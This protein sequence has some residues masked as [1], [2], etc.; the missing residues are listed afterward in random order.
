MGLLRSDP[1]DSFRTVV[2]RLP[3]AV[4]D[5]AGA[6]RYVSPA[7]ATLLGIDQ[8]SLSDFGSVV[9]PADVDAVADAFLTVRDGDV[10]ETR[11]TFRGTGDERDSVFEATLVDCGGSTPVDC[12][13]STPADCGEDPVPADCDDTTDP[14]TDLGGVLVSLADVTR[15]ERLRRVVLSVVDP[16]DGVATARTPRAVVDRL[17]ELTEGLEAVEVGCY[18]RGDETAT[19]RPVRE[20]APE[21]VE[22]VVRDADRTGRVVAVDAA[23]FPLAGLPRGDYAAGV[24][25]PLG[26]HGVLVA[27]T[28]RETDVTAELVAF[29]RVAAATTALALDRL[30]DRRTLRGALRASRRYQTGRDRLADTVDVER[31]A[32][33]RILAASSTTEV[34]RAVCEELVSTDSVAFAWFGTVSPEGD[35]V[36]R[37]TA[38]EGGDYLS[39]VSFVPDGDDRPPV[40]RAVSDRTTVVE[41]DLSA[42]FESVGWRR[43]ALDA[44]FRSALA[45]PVGGDDATHGVLVCYGRAV[46][47]FDGPIR[48]VVDHLTRTVE[49]ALTTVELR[50]LALGNTT[51]ELVLSITAEDSLLSGLAAATGGTVQFESASAIEGGQTRV[52]VTVDGPTEAAVAAIR[53]VETVTEVKHL[54]DRDDGVVLEVVSDGRTIPGTLASLGAVVTDAETTGSGV[55]V[56]VTVSRDTPVREFV[57]S[58]RE[59][60]P[61]TTLLARR[62]AE[63]PVEANLRFRRRVEST[64]TERQLETLQTAHYGGY[65]DSPRSRTGSDIAAMLDITQ[66]TFASHLREA[67]RKLLTLLFET[68]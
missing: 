5:P 30:D 25:V 18:L 59:T 45:V 16:A 31:R 63:S 26:D 49:H 32:E 11:V 36:T 12:G 6:V 7:A 3:V 67:Q 68:T 15:S 55:R 33:R 51:I 8:P 35:L 62:T 66:P 10:T 34:Q 40:T 22:S 14:G 28:R 60:Y 54:L 65:F 50:E 29:L 2:E 41:R 47:A 56:T 48:G 4:L 38:G 64:F 44:G 46:G 24:A 20:G 39:N 13:G 37:A 17:V 57:D 52:F 58:V 61:E 43:A 42:G 21:T 9:A 53:E 1:F 19:L 27:G 23:S